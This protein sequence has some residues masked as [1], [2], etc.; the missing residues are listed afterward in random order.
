[1]NLAVQLVGAIIAGIVIVVGDV[2]SIIKHLKHREC[3]N[4]MILFAD[5]TRNSGIAIIIAVVFALLSQL[6]YN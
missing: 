5:L 2:S 4:T 6:F 1:M 3:D